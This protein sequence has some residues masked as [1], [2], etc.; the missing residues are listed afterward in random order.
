[1]G[2][3]LIAVL[4]LWVSLAATAIAGD[5]DLPRLL[6]CHDRAVGGAALRAADAVA[7]TLR[8]EEPGFSVDGYYRATRAGAM[9][10]DVYDGGRRVFSEGWDGERGWQRRAGDEEPVP[11]SGAAAAPLVHGLEGPG[12]LWTLADMIRT[13]HTLELDSPELLDGKPMAVLK[14]TLADGFETVYLLDPESCL[15][16]QSRNVRA[17]H[18]D[19]DPGERRIA[20]HYMDHR[21]INGVS[22]PLLTRNVDLDSGEILGTT[23]IVFFTTAPNLH[24]DEM[25]GTADIQWS[26]V[27][28]PQ[29]ND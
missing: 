23:R 27:P 24:A 25:R 18:P 13:G 7:Y 29:R 21:K 19:I 12:H 10:I 8:I 14:L 1:M 20:T 2:I 11:I 26:M 5:D 22:R 6:A 3:T 16:L 4:V 17:F 15:I 9:R 28:G